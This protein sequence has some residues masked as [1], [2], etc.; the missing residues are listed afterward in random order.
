MKIGDIIVRENH[1]ADSGRKDD[2]IFIYLGKGYHKNS[3]ADVLFLG[4][5]TE[6]YGKEKRL[7]SFSGW[8]TIMF[9]GLMKFPLSYDVKISNEEKDEVIKKILGDSQARFVIIRKIFGETKKP[10]KYHE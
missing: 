4:M 1:T 10:R 9:N 7:L 8:R 5:Y 6:T 3:E 2:E